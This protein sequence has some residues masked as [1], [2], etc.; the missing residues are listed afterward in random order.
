MPLEEMSMEVGA[1]GAA[2]VELG[3]VGCDEDVEAG[4]EAGL[5]ENDDVAR[6][7]GLVGAV[8]VLDEPKLEKLKLD[9]ME[10]PEEAG[11]AGVLG[12]S[13]MTDAEG[14][15]AF[16]S[17]LGRESVLPQGRVEG[18]AEGGGLF[19]AGAG[20]VE[21]AGAEKEDGDEGEPK[22][23]GLDPG[24][25]E[26][27]TVGLGRFS[28]PNGLEDAA[29]VDAADEAVDAPKEKDEVVDGLKEVAAK[30]FGAGELEP[31]E[32]AEPAEPKVK[33]DPKAGFDGTGAYQ[34][35]RSRKMDR[36]DE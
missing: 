21:A 27:V 4:V 28:E 1:G 30:G 3:L 24:D 35:E 12:G 23:N 34:V 31:K 33:V 15:E 7:D 29:D 5:N 16:L 6:G 13:T 32:P 36:S 8:L 17:L 10:V 11:I 2:E 14:L 22:E 20:V 19:G 18:V 26:G 25:A 9:L